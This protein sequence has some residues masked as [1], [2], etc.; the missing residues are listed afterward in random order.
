MTNQLFYE[1]VHRGQ[2]H[3]QSTCLPGRRALN[4][5]LRRSRKKLESVRVRLC[6][7]GG[8]YQWRGGG[9][10]WLSAPS[11]VMKLMHKYRSWQM[12][13]WPFC[14]IINFHFF[15]LPSWIRYFFS[16]PV[17]FLF[18]S[19]PNIFLARLP[20]I[21]GPE[22]SSSSRHCAVTW[23]EIKLTER[24]LNNVLHHLFSSLLL[25]RHAA[26]SNIDIDIGEL[27]TKTR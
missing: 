11:R 2:I 16:P 14:L 8:I 19:K 21:R 23:N 17:H 7:G 12:R 27:T 6:R 13:S 26:D 10:G 20:D 22:A 1:A 18:R 4:H 15:T 5:M 25:E 3:S 9:G 24:G